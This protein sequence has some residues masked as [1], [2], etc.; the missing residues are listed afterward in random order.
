MPSPLR[1]SPVIKPVD[2]FTRVSEHFILAD[3]LGNQSVYSRG[4]ANPL[5]GDE[6]SRLKLANLSALAAHGLEPI[7]ANWGPLTVSYG[8]ISP[9]VS[10]QVV[11][12]QDPDQPSHHRFD[13]GAAVD[14][15][16]HDWVQGEYTVLG[17]LYLPE[18]ARGSPIALAHGF[19]MIGIPYSRI[20]TYSE[21]PYICLAV[22]SA[23]VAQG[24]PRNAFYE[25]RF[26]GSPKAK[27][28]YIQ[29]STPQA[30]RRNLLQL[31]ELG[32]E[33]D[34]QGAGYPTY[35]GGGYRQYQHMRVSRYTMVSDWLFDLQSIAN[36]AK[37]IPA[38]NED[39]VLDSLAAAGIVY[40]WMIQ[41]YG[42]KRM[43]IVGGYVS[44][45]NPYFD[46]ENDWAAG[47]RISFSVVPP[48]GWD[49]TAMAHS[50]REELH[51][52]AYAEI[53]DNGSIKVTVG[54][55]EVLN[56]ETYEPA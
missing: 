3:F 45:L 6:A 47:G 8:Y 37:N 30:R 56:D 50:L 26:T 5:I 41:S 42:V 53:Q 39:S 27:P 18:S 25:N 43:S 34:W 15:C 4:Y 32:L 36:G 31:Q 23:E 2:P 21:S 48:A 17:D 33:R 38:L 16:V 44:H 28:E 52:A 46:P 35:H 14:I 11:K 49:A 22:S 13:L 24:R 12:Y 1:R 40:D 20:I 51:G 55:D 10:R 29:L 54:V 9:A 19:E 7:L